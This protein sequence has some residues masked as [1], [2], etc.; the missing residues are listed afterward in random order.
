MWDF[1]LR[2]IEIVLFRLNSGGSFERAS[3]WVAHVKIDGAFL[4]LDSSRHY[5]N[6]SQ[7]VGRE[8]GQGFGKLLDIQRRTHL[9][10]S[11]R[12]IF[13]HIVSR[14]LVY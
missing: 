14:F 6:L 5:R 7:L 13:C 11:I 10:T 4:Q 8:V 1:G 2:H 9:R 12:F 3:A